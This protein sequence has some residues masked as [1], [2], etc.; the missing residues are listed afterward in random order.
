M[1]ETLTPAGCGG[2]Q[3]SRIALLLFTA[4]AVVGAAAVGAVAGGLGA[5]L[6]A[7]RVRI[8]LV[9]GVVAIALAR[10]AGLVRVPVPALRRQ[11]PEAWRR[12]LPLPV[13]T[14]GYGAILGTGLGTYQPTATLWATLATIVAIGDPIM[15]AVCMAAFGLARGIMVRV[16]VAALVEHARPGRSP[17]RI[18]NVAV[19]ALILATLAP[20][21]AGQETPVLAGRADPSVSAGASAATV[22][23]DGAASVVVTPTGAESIV[24]PDAREPSL[25][26]SAV[27][28]TTARGVEV[29]LWRT[30]QVLTVIPGAVRPAL[31]GRYLGYV[32]VTPTGARLMVRDLRTGVTRLI[33]RVGPSVDLGRP[34]ISGRLVVWHEASGRRSRILMRPIGGRVVVLAETLRRW[35]VTYPSIARG[36]VVWVESDAERS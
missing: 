15:G 25:S 1:V 4:G 24:L 3:R 23:A 9:L 36:R 27:A 20:Q 16:P 29:R 11:V 31:A 19:L 32:L 17:L 10:E 8:A 18:A 35:Q 12:R 6:P 33:T 28:V 22:H 26:T 13:W 34:S 21:A 14:T 2:R 5:I 7:G 30:G